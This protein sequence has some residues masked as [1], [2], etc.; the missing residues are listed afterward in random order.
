MQIA[1]V[2]DKWTGA[3][4]EVTIGATKDQGGTRDKTVTVGGAKGMRRWILWVEH[5]FDATKVA[6]LYKLKI[7]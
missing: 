5:Q 4:K 7:F 6:T 2:A 3:V 1:N